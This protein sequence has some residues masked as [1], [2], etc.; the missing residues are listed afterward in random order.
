MVFGQSR[1][2]DLLM[3]VVDRVS[4]KRLE[5]MKVVAG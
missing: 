4:S 1:Q 3:Y 2:E 5:E